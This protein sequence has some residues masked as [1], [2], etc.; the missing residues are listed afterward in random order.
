[1]IKNAFVLL[2]TISLARKH[3]ALHRTQHTT[4]NTQHTTHNTQH[5]THNTHRHRH[6]HAETLAQ[7]RAVVCYL[8]AAPGAARTIGCVPALMTGHAGSL[9]EVNLPERGQGK[10]G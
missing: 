5:T 1:M 4:H 6:T 9:A 2:K 8:E 3:R 7:S 10:E